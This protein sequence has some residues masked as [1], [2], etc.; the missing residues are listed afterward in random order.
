[1]ERKF[2][3]SKQIFIL[4]GTIYTR[5]GIWVL[6]CTCD[7]VGHAG[8][9]GKSEVRPR[10][11]GKTSVWPLGADWSGRKQP[12]RTPAPGLRASVLRAGALGSAGSVASGSAL[13]WE[14]PYCLRPPRSAV[15]CVSQSSRSC[16][17]LFRPHPN[18]PSYFLHWVQET[19]YMSKFLFFTDLIDSS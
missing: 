2:S 15:A 17:P 9:Y 4:E 1:M 16:L 6:L 10:S 3:Y 12:R 19:I 13:A 8:S 14:T 18:Q 11:S 5:V 7:V